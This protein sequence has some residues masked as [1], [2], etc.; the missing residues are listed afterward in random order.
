[1]TVEKA[2]M[3]FQIDGK[4]YMALTT[5]IDLDLVVTLLASLYEE[6]MVKMIPLPEGVHFEKYENLKATSQ[7]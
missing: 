4:C 1:M 2:S 3:I 7:P 5:G 6:G